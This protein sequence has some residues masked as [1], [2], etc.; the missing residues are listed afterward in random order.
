[1][2]L[3]Q[4]PRL[5]ELLEAWRGVAEDPQGGGLGSPLPSRHLAAGARDQVKQEQ[6]VV[7]RA[8]QVVRALLLA[9]LKVHN[10]I[11]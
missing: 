8:L 2:Y 5:A 6:E 11:T 4:H 10:L 9:L 3:S 1:M 7:S